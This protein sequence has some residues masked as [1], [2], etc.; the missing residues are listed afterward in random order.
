MD[1]S[2]LIECKSEFL[3]PH[4]ITHIPLSRKNQYASKETEDI[5]M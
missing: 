1:V 5:V 3:I 2:E 4:R